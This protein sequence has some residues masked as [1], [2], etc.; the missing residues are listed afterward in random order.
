MVSLGGAI[1]IGS[2]VA[3]LF[4]KKK[5][6]QGAVTQEQKPYFRPITES[7][8]DVDK[9]L[10]Y[11]K[12][13]KTYQ[14]PMMRRVNAGDIDGAFTPKAI[15]EMQQYVDDEAA[16]PNLKELDIDLDKL[17]REYVQSYITEANLNPA[18]AQ[19]LQNRSFD[20]KT[21]AKAV[22]EANKAPH[23]NT[24][25]HDILK[26]QGLGLALNAAGRLGVTK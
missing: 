17:G 8:S 21:I 3:G 1:S 6:K 16:N 2:S 7:L 19:A 4:G 9:I 11:T 20:Y 25:S 15:F 18:Y 14:A 13:N 23:V 5:Q 10:D 12:K 22:M 24:A 26:Q